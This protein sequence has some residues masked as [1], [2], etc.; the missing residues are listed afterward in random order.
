M[1]ISLGYSM[2]ICECLL[3]PSSTVKEPFFDREFFA[4][5]LSSS[6]PASALGV[7]KGHL[8]STVGLLFLSFRNLESLSPL[9][10]FLHT[11]CVYLQ[12]I[13]YLELTPN[14]HLACFFSLRVLQC[15]AFLLRK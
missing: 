12:H 3:F 2:S 11:A 13:L 8:F 4:A 7:E 1:M 15:N 14:P 5:S 10:C 6:P 9:F